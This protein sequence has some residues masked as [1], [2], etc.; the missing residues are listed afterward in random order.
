[1]EIIIVLD[2]GLVR[3]VCIDGRPV[4]A[5]VR[6]YDIEGCE[7]SELERDSDGREYLPWTVN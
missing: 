6:D 7:P 1:M 2:G 4:T 5:T 3:D